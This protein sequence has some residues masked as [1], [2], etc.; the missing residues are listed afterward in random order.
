MEIWTLGLLVWNTFEMFQFNELLPVKAP[1]DINW[2]IIFLDLWMLLLMKT[3]ECYFIVCFVLCLDS[4][5]CFIMMDQ[6]VVILF[7]NNDFVI[8]CVTGLACFSVYVYC[9][10]SST[11]LSHLQPKQ[12]W[13]C[14]LSWCLNCVDFN[15][16]W[17]SHC[18]VH[19]LL[20]VLVQLSMSGLA[21]MT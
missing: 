3:F 12:D 5:W 9:H 16:H 10:L 18:V 6:F 20:E 4:V 17:M 21:D 2:H 7:P 19:V 14:I 11:N 13:S 8:V 1:I 15:V